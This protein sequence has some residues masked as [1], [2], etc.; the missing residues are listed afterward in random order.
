MAK[1]GQWGPKLLFDSIESTNTCISLVLGEIC[2]AF[3][4]ERARTELTTRR[5][6]NSRSQRNINHP[7]QNLSSILTPRVC[8]TGCPCSGVRTE[9]SPVFGRIV[10]GNDNLC[11]WVIFL[12][13]GCYLALSLSCDLRTTKTTFVGLWK[14]PN[15]DLSPRRRD[16]FPSF[17]T[18]APELQWALYLSLWSRLIR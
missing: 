17:P 14:L 4:G 13:H 3:L 10:A 6:K 8:R 16:G 1:D 7:K 15:I 5:N 11:V 12:E 2:T 18:L 9:H